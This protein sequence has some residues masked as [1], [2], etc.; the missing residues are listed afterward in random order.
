MDISNNKWYSSSDNAIMKIIGAFIRHHRLEQN[1]TQGQLAEEAGINRSTLIE[2]EQGKHAN[3]ITLI[4]LLRALN[5]LYVLEPFKVE[6]QMSPIQLA[7][8][9]QSYRKRAS[10]S[11]KN[12]KPESDW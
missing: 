2:I 8:M 11:K 6:K 9:E 12:K 3:V 1:K 5:Q 10:G 7:E 4:Q